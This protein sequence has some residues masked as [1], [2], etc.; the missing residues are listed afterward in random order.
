MHTLIQVR[1]LHDWALLPGKHR[2][3]R[4]EAHAEARLLEADFRYHR[5]FRQ[6]EACPPWVMGQEIGWVLPSPLAMTLTPIVDVQVGADE[7]LDDAHLAAGM[8]EFYINA[9]LLMDADIPRSAIHEA[10]TWVPVGN[11]V[12]YLIGL[13]VAGWFSRHNQVHAISFSLSL[14][15]LLLMLYSLLQISATT[16]PGL[17]SP[18]TEPAVQ[19]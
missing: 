16:T 13:A 18:R 7:E 17:A 11:D 1:R 6:P 10:N 2:V 8:T 3:D 4:Q 19:A 9:Y 5:A 12:G 15:A 14:A